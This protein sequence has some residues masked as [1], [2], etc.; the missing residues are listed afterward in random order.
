MAKFELFRRDSGEILTLV[1][2]LFIGL[3]VYVF[4]LSYKLILMG[5]KGEFT[6]LAEFSGMKLYLCSV[7]PGLVLAVIM[8]FILICGV[9]RILHPHNF[10]NKR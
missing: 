9:P 5:V 10:G 1:V 6:V 3:S 4:H 8:A 7:T 2:L